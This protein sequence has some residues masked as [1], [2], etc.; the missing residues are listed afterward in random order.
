MFMAPHGGKKVAMA[1]YSGHKPKGRKVS[2]IIDNTAML[3]PLPVAPVH[4]GMRV[5]ARMGFRP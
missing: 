4:A 5:V 3:A 1:G 2:A